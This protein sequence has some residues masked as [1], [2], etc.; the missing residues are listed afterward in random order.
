MTTGKTIA[1][2]R[3]TFVGKVMSLP[4]NMRSR[5]VIT[6]LPRSK[7]LLISWL[8]S[9]SA[10][11][12]EPPTI[13]YLTVSPSICHEV[14]GLS[15]MF[16]LCL[17]YS[18][19]IPCPISSATSDTGHICLSSWNASWICSTKPIN[20]YGFFLPKTTIGLSITLSEGSR[21]TLFLNP[22]PIWS[23]SGGGMWS[24]EQEFEGGEM[25]CWRRCRWWSWVPLIHS[26]IHLSK[27]QG[28]GSVL[29]CFKGALYLLYDSYLPAPPPL[30]PPCL[31]WCMGGSL[32]TK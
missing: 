2:T 13:K 17:L 18:L 4:F 24:Q 28:K 5:L 29:L 15:H 10:V 7:C 3:Q 25:R 31:Q 16:R 8:Q 27:K 22:Y 21:W 11:I 9:P 20:T 6:F 12:L 32:T 26:S 1:L 19:W 30:A 14:M 23:E